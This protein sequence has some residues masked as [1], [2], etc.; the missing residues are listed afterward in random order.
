MTALHGKRSF[1]AAC[2]LWERGQLRSAFTMFRRLAQKG[3]V[4]AQVNLAHFY[5]EGLA[6]PRD[7]KAAQHW[8]RCAFRGGATHAA[9]NIGINYWYDGRVTHAEKWLS[10]AAK[11][12]D[13]DAC[14]ELARFYLF[15]LADSK[16]SRTAAKRV[17]A[18][19]NVT[20]HSRDVA[21]AMLGL[22]R[23][24]DAKLVSSSVRNGR[25]K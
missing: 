12:G 24:A 7:M 2:E 21:R 3:D 8:L 19:E 18:S 11:Q 10:K 6:S 15:G 1:A 16:R 20:S 17:L 5:S 22:S 4:S 25:K 9:T 23:G 13:G 14:L